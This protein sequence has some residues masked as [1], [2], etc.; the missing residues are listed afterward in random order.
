[1]VESIPIGWRLKKQKYNLIGTQCTTC[2]EKFFPVRNFCPTCRRKGAIEDFQFSGKG[3]IESFTII[4][5]APHGFES[6]T[7]Y[8]VG[9]IKLDEG[10]N[11]SGQIVADVTKVEIG[12]RVHPVFRRQ[13]ED[14]AEGIIHYGIKFALED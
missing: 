13:A 6:Q 4:R 12:K 7:P 5:T 8:A 10:T 9:I 1:M 14:G 3:A 2:G 11:I